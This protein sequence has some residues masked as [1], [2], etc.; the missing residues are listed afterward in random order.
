MY[1]SKHYKYL[2]LILKARISVS[3]SA[4]DELEG[5]DINQDLV[6]LL[7]GDLGRLINKGEIVRR[8]V[9]DSSDQVV[10]FE[11]FTNYEDPEELSLSDVTGE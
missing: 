1:D 2:D 9:C 4:E 5:Y 7:A 11:L 3:V 10:H 6:S 8:L